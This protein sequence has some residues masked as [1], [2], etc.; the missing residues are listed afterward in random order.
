VN[1]F[2]IFLKIIF[3]KIFSEAKEMLLKQLLENPDLLPPDE[4]EKLIANLIS[5]LSTFDR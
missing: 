1:G 5:N 3:F 4:R 2:F